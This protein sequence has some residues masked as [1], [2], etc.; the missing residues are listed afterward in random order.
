MHG[1]AGSRGAGAA[2]AAAAFVLA[3]GRLP[4][5]RPGSLR[6]AC[7]HCLNSD[8]AFDSLTSPCRGFRRSDGLWPR[9][10]QRGSRACYFSVASP[11]GVF[12]SFKNFAKFL[13]FF[14]ISNL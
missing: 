7:L 12:F 4:F 5:E 1:I 11:C 14:V 8:D 13:R 6:S 9:W 3:L 10:A 2:T